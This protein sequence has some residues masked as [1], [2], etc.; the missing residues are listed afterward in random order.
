MD[1]TTAIAFYGLGAAA[2]A[3]SVVTLRKRLELSQAKHKSLAGH[4][5]IARRLAAFV[6][7][8]D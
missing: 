8:Y 7:F 5:R 1:G 3:T 6:P 4:S 2:V